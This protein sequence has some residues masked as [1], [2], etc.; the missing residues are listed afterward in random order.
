MLSF[1]RFDL[2]T[3]FHVIGPVG[4]VALIAHANDSVRVEHPTLTALRAQLHGSV[5]KSVLVNHY[6]YSIG[7]P[8]V[9]Q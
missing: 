1:P 5:S 9:C 8:I 6:T 2:G 4:M 7:Y 3:A